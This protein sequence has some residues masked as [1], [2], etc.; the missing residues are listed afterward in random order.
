ML[1]VIMITAVM[2]AVVMVAVAVVHPLNKCESDKQICP[3]QSLLCA[4]LSVDLEPP[5]PA[6]EII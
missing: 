1:L 3:I 2:I 4:Q 5:T 6:Y